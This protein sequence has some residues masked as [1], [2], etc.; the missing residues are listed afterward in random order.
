[1]P[2]GLD[3]VHLIVN[4]YDPEDEI[5][6]K[7]VE[8]SLNMKVFGTIAQRLRLGHPVDQ[9][10]EAGRAVGAPSR[11]TSGTYRPWRPRLASEGRDPD[12]GERRPEFWHGCSVHRGSRHRPMK[13]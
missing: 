5:S 1:M 8:R 4:R 11:P 2:R 9:L 3:Q 12:P 6:L 13:R 7:D 10:R